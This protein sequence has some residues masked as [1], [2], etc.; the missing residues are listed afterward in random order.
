MNFS[1]SSPLRPEMESC[2]LLLQL[3]ALY[4]IMSQSFKVEV[5]I[6]TDSYLVLKLLM[7]IHFSLS[8]F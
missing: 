4:I 3:S 1:G 8:A 2:I 7:G 5:F 6:W